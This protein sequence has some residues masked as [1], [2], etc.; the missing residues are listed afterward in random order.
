MIDSPW[1]E[2]KW[3][4]PRNV[5]ALITTRGENGAFN[6]A[7]HVNDDPDRVASNRG[8]LLNHLA[9]AKRIGWLNQ[10]HGTDVV[11]LDSYDW[12]HIPSADA[13][14][15][16]TVGDVSAVMTADC[17]PVLF[18]SKDGRYVA[19][20]H[21][22][23]RGLQQGVLESTVN[24][25]PTLPDNLTVFLGPAISQMN[26]EVGAEVKQAF[27][28]VAASVQHDAVAAAFLPSP[29]HN[30]KWMANLYALARLR[31][32]AAGVVDIQ[33]GGFCTM[34][35]EKRFY[36]YRRDPNCGRMA[37]LIYITS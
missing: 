30:G 35:D 2:P 11:N 1:F 10:V 25:I 7:Q 8:T 24:A 28:D 33:G 4:L 13:S 36:S 15:T 18:A 31:L 17:L 23:W 16:S 3:E 20:A 34:L 21:A 22:G 5:R 19:A 6:L 26:F 14:V 12:S 27:L 29:F 9:G 32:R 37:S